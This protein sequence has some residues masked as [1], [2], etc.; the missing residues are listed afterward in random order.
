MAAVRGRTLHEFGQAFTPF[1]ITIGGATVYSINSGTAL[2]GVFSNWEKI[3]IS[4]KTDGTA[5]Y[6]KFAFNRWQLPVM[7]MT[8]FETLRAVQGTK[9]T[10][11]ETNSIDDRNMPQQYLTAFVEDVVNGDHQGLQVTNVT[12]TF[13]VDVTT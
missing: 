13:R 9:I 1:F 10:S 12:I 7:N 8:D 3:I 2:S 6:S 11:L 5:R 4:P